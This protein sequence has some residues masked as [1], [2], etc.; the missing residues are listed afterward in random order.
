MEKSAGIILFRERKQREYLLL[1]Y[2]ATYWGLAK[3]KIEEGETEEQ[4]AVR[5]AEEETGLEKIK[6]VPGF[7]DKIK[8]FFT[9]EEQKIYKQ[10]VWFL[11]EVL[12]EVDGEISVEHEDL[13]WMN[14]EDAGKRITYTKDRQVFEKAV[15][16]LARYP[17]H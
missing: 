11:G 13:V 2:H 17:P 6:I 16:F 10:V 9:R 15:R 5:E 1:K 3:G 7:K 4:A 14:E 12:D 8:Y